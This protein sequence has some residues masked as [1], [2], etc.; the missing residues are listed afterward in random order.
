LQ[1]IAN[2]TLAKSAENAISE[3]NSDK[4]LVQVKPAPPVCPLS[5]LNCIAGGGLSHIPGFPAG[6]FFRSRTG[7]LPPFLPPTPDCRKIPCHL[8]VIVHLTPI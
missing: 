1:E 5:T 3:G 8:P 7:K 6:D 2:Q 4:F